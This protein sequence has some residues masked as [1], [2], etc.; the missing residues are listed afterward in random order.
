MI[1]PVAAG[2]ATACAIGNEKM[3]VIAIEQMP[4]LTV[5]ILTLF[6]ITY[7]PDIVLFLPRLLGYGH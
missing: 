4:F 3:E 5:A 6:L 1:P 2:L 7:V